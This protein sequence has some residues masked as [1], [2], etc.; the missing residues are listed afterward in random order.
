MTETQVQIINKTFAAVLPISDAAAELFY[1]RLFEINPGVRA[2]FKGDMKEQGRKLMHTIGTAVGAARNLDSLRGPLQELAK[3]HVKYGVR[4]EHF[5]DV[6]SALIH[7][8][9]K[10][11][12]SQF[13]PEAKVAWVSLYGEIVG[14]MVPALQRASSPVRAAPVPP[15]TM[16]R[17]KKQRSIFGAI[18]GW[19]GIKA[20]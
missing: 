14:I 16:P 13:T 20:G 1:N 10:G 2:M 17:A 8:L 7:T 11:L 12:G 19:F 6:G 15:V 18:L 3:R 5:D 4:P 9:E